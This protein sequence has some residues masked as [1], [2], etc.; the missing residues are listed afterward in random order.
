[1][2]T[3]GGGIVSVVCHGGAIFSGALDPFTNKPIIS[4]KKVI[5][6]T[7]RGVE[8]EG[9][10]H[11]IKSWKRPTIEA[12]AK[13]AGATCENANFTFSAFYFRISLGC[14]I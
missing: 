10:L 11:T 3:Q 5:G 2:Y 9:V 6:S 14:W 12:R 13:G 1:M 8:E 4:G 7:A